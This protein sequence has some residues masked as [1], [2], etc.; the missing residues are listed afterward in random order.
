MGLLE[1]IK[2]HLE[3]KGKNMTPENRYIQNQD[4]YT[5]SYFIDSKKTLEDYEKELEI[6]PSNVGSIINMS[7][8]LY[9]LGRYEDALKAC[10]R[11]IAI[12]LQDSTQRIDK[13]SAWIN[14]G[15][16]LNF[17]GRYED[18]LKACDKAI[19][20]NPHDSAALYN[21]GVVLCNLGWYTDAL[22]AYD[23]YLEI[24]PE[25]TYV[26]NNRGVVLCN[27][28]RFQD[29]KKAYVKAIK[30]YPEFVLAHS[31][32]GELFFNLGN[33]EG[34]SK[35]SNDALK[36]LAL[37]R[38][39]NEFEKALV[40]S[41]QGKIKIEEQDY[42]GA[43][44][45]F[46]EAIPL[47]LGDPLLSLWD[48]YANYL[49]IEFSL[50][51]NHSK[52]EKMV[53]I[54]RTLEKAEKFSEKS[55]DKIRAGILYFSGC[56]YYKIEDIFA[57]KEKLEKCIQLKTKSSIKSSS[58]ELLENIWI[59]KIK[60]SWWQWWL[61]SP[62]H[63]W[64]KRIVFMILSSFIFALLTLYPYN[65]ILKNLQINPLVIG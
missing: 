17:L 11:A 31:N 58:C 36:L 21:Q 37:P 45:C 8:T 64:P 51:S 43:S 14:K 44:K 28:G 59:Y 5:A 62:L 57:A 49:D 19:A 48:A 33:L 3:K 50:I 61:T 20:I 46:K 42:S 13:G 2:K 16:I 60:P 35:E 34:S 9:C 24:F 7:M 15:M 40:L 47:K 12:N 6:N 39:A 10:D 56:F 63:C 53:S 22:K 29:A 25:Y 30:I 54:I 1:L 52:K 23:K 4:L 38:L 65:E 27:L 41:L 18:A 26:W 55:D 32:L